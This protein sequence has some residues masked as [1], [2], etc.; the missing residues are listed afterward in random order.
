MVRL[1]LVVDKEPV[2]AVGV[3]V[4]EGRGTSR[5]DADDDNGGGR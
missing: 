5:G 3:V 1:L 4:G 2:V